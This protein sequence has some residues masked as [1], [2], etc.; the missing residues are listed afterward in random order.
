MGIMI[1]RDTRRG[2]SEGIQKKESA[3]EFLFI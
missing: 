2:G 3:Q 1:Y